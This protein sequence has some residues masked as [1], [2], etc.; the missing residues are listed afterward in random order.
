MEKEK[1]ETK[2]LVFSLGQCRNANGKHSGLSTARGH[3][4]LT[5]FV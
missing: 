1:Y 4:A 3:E 5:G 2:R